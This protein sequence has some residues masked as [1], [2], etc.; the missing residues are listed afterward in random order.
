MIPSS[1]IRPLERKRIQQD[2]DTPPAE[3]RIILKVEER[4]LRMASQGGPH[5]GGEKGVQWTPAAQVIV[6]A[7][8]GPK[9]L[10]IAGIEIHMQKIFQEQRIR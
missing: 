1:I 4:S 8:L 5:P 2:Y 7:C 3:E 10:N 9:K 6:P